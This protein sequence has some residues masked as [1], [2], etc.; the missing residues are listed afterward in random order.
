MVDGGSSS[1][2]IGIDSLASGGIQMSK[3]FRKAISREGHVYHGVVYDIELCDEGGECASLVTK[4]GAGEIVDWRESR[5]GIVEVVLGAT[6]LFLPRWYFER[7]FHELPELGKR[8]LSKEEF[9]ELEPDGYEAYVFASGE[10][11]T[12][13][14]CASALCPDSY[15][16]D[17][18]AV[19]E[20]AAMITPVPQLGQDASEG[21]ATAGDSLTAPTS[22]EVG[23]PAAL[24]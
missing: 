18:A 20:T 12:V 23:F 9:L 13:R 14:K 2:I 16:Q 11:V 8:Y 22:Y 7:K 17:W 4:V 24:L 5:W 6:S 15:G 21:A 10:F 19:L 3:G 1:G